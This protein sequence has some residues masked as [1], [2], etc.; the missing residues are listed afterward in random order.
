MKQRKVLEKQL[1]LF[2]DTIEPLPSIDTLKDGIYN[3]LHYKWIFELETGEKY[4]MPFGIERERDYAIM[5]KFSINSG[6]LKQI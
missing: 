5:T 2:D 6:K 1:Y 4:H 3:G